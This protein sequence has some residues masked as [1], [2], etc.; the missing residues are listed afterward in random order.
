MQFLLFIGCGES[1]ND[2]NRNDTST[3][4]YSTNKNPSV[5]V[6]NNEGLDSVYSVLINDT[7]CEIIFSHELPSSIDSSDLSTTVQ[8]VQKHNHDTLYK[9]TFDFNT[10]GK[11]VQAAPGIFFIDLYNS[12]GGSGFTGSIFYLKTAPEISLRPVCKFDEL[13]Y[14]KSSNSGTQLILFDGIWNMNI[15]PDSPDFETHFSDHQQFITEYDI[16]TDT[17]IANEIGST[18][19]KYSVSENESDV[20]STLKDFRKKEPHM[21]DKIRWEN[22]GW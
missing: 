1:K 5:N 20:E 9:K 4:P 16:K 12:Y 11:V 22:Y 18:K 2:V 7:A 6:L 3:I 14:W 8:V 19:Y 13:S 17:V 15:N 21:A 10:V